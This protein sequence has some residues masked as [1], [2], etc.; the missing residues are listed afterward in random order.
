MLVRVADCE[1]DSQTH[2]AH[3]NGIKKPL[4]QRFLSLKGVDPK[5]LRNQRFA[6][7]Y[8]NGG[9]P[10]VAAVIPK[11]VAAKAATAKP[12]AAKPAAKGAAKEAKGKAPAKK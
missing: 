10:K 4:K 3:R 5:F 9:R 2:K 6:K 7:K 1:R 12:A 11:A 8:N